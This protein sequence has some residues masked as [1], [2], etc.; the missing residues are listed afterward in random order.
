MLPLT[1]HT[2]VLEKTSTPLSTIEAFIIPYT[3]S[4]SVDATNPEDTELAAD[5][6]DPLPSAQAEL[7]CP[8]AVEFL[9]DIYVE[10]T[11]QGID[12][13]ESLKAATELYN[14]LAKELDPMRQR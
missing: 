10:K 13:D 5:L 7:P 9:A 14:N 12:T 11:S 3:K 8:L 4:K 6:D 2:S 1:V